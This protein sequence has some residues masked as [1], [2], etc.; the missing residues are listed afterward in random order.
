MVQ[1]IRAKVQPIQTN[2]TEDESY[3]Q[4]F[5]E[6]FSYFEKWERKTRE[7]ER[8][9]RAEQLGMPSLVMH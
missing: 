5:A 2:P 8:R 3:K 9:E 4:V 7:Q 1:R 6:E